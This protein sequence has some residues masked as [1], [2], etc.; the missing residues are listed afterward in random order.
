MRPGRYEALQSNEGGGRQQQC[1]WNPP[2]SA[3]FHQHDP[4]LEPTA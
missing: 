1:P 4:A 3:L 2:P